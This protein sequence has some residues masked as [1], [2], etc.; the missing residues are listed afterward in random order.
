MY[1]HAHLHHSNTHTHKNNIPEFYYL[2][3]EA[4]NSINELEDMNENGNENGNGNG[5]E[6]KENEDEELND[7]INLIMNQTNNKATSQI[8]KKKG[9]KFEVEIEFTKIVGQ[10]KKIFNFF[11]QS[12]R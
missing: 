8:K 9:G 1:R 10:N 2:I 5:N 12:Q 3:I 6:E 4:R 7:D 11:E